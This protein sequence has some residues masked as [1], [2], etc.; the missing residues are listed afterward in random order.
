MKSALLLAVSALAAARA[1]P[2]DLSGVRP[3]PVTVTSTAASATVH[4]SDE[5]GR[6]WTAEFS[7]D[8]QAPLITSIAMGGA[9]V[10]EHAR[11]F[12]QCQTGKRRGGWDAF[13]DFPPSHPEGTRA[14]LGEFALQSARA[15]TIG[16]RL[17]I[18]F[19]GL[20]MGVFTG[21]I[22]Y[23]FFPGSRLVEQ[24]AVMTTH[25]PDTAYFYDAG[26]RIAVDRDRRPGGN[27]ESRVWYYDTAGKLRTLFSSGPER[28]P[29]QVRYRAIAA[30]TGTGSLAVFPAPHRYFFPRDYTTN[31]GYVWHSSWRGLVS[32]GI[33]QLP[34]DAS[35]YYP[36][37]NAPPGT[38]QRMSLFLLLHP[39]DPHAALDDVLRFTHYDRFPALEGYT[40]FAPHWHFAYTVQAME[41]GADWVP[42]FKTV[43]QAMGVNAAMIMDFHGDGHPRDLTELRLRELQA[44]YRDCRAQS[45]P[46]FL[47]IPAEEANVHFGGHWALAF[48]KPVYWF[49]DRKPGQP[50]REHD[51][52]FGT[53]YRTGNAAE[54]LD[55][56]RAENAWVYQTHPRTKGSTGFPDQIRES[57]QFLDPHYF[58]AGWKALPSDLSSPRLGDRAFKLLDDMSNWGVPKRLVGEVDV[59]QIDPTHEL[60]AHMNV[61]YVKLPALPAF[62]DYGRLLDAL[63]RGDFFTTTGEVLLPEVSIRDAGGGRIA[64]HA[65][66]VHTFPLE[67]AEIV[68]G[69]GSET[70]RK[71]IPLTS[72]HPFGDFSFSAEADAGDWKW[73]RFAVCDVAAGGAFVNPAWRSH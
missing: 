15:V 70:R 26:L 40:T 68:W 19:E 5:A 18:T 27:M 52:R 28:Q 57:A 69:N 6:A 46:D 39:A 45:G 4:W 30:R 56:V 65:R 53:V 35:P 41:K 47:L 62:D 67:M 64:V 9:P 17:E 21:S 31:L 44:F 73:A 37:S 42:P 14:F 71:A 22:R 13:F 8:P 72:T 43:L 16:D 24:A 60:Y 2:L 63:R 12:Y 66:I 51:A 11:P 49:M 61:N 10:V 7:L 36:W 38:P 59:F 34:D 20:R 29:L 3:G 32:L 25:E 50:Q 54:L 48:P 55:L 33:R 23:V 58:G 1:V